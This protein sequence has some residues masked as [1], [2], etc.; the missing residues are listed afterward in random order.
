MAQTHV[1]GAAT[2]R[3]DNAYRPDIRVDRPSETNGA[4]PAIVAAAFAF[5]VGAF[6]LI[7]VRRRRSPG[8]RSVE[9]R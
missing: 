3:T 9:G 2:T 8:A 1:E 7:V 5:A 6:A 4:W